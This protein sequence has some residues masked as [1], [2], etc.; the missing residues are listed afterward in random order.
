MKNMR[1]MGEMGEEE[2]FYKFLIRDNAVVGDSDILNFS[3]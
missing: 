1:E 2:G 3:F